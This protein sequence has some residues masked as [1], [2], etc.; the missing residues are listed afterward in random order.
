MFMTSES[1]VARV[2]IALAVWLLASNARASDADSAAA[3]VL[4]DQAKKLMAEGAYV[5]ACAKLE[6]SQR[7]DPGSGTL[8]NLGDCYEHQGRTAT[9][10]AKFIEAAEASKAVG[11]AERERAARE[12]AAFVFA[13]L[14]RIVVD[15][16]DSEK[17]IGLEVR[18]DGVAVA[19]AQW[20]TAMAVDPGRHTV[21]ASAPARAPWETSVVVGP[22]GQTVTVAVPVLFARSGAAEGQDKSGEG[23]TA[24]RATIALAPAPPRDAQTESQGLGTQRILALVSGGVGVAGLTLGTV[25]GLQSQSKHDDA[26][27]HCTGEICREQ[28]G[29]DLKAEAKVAGNLST[30]AFVLG[31]AGLAGGAVLWFSAPSAPHGAATFQVRARPAG[32]ALQ[33]TW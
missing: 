7:L 22:G 5:E 8:I 24:E 3:Q 21:S 1:S 17:G 30:V 29:V 6:D 4:F 2:A 11:K 32:I 27:N 20:G 23:A 10:W 18:R 28:A 31:A 13:H 12:R 19:K 14:S 25:F 16:R 26:E 33:G 9:A 15:V